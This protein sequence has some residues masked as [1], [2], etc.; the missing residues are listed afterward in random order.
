MDWFEIKNWLELSTG[1]DRDSLHIYAGVGVQLIVALILRRS[2]ASPVPW[3]LVAV[4]ALTN[5]YYDYSFVPDPLNA[6]QEYFDGAIRDVWNTLLLPS[7][8]LVI[9]RY[10]PTWLTGRAKT[11]GEP[12]KLD[13]ANPPI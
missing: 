13:R 2:L 12:E 1:L 11:V 6:T 4:A 8:L 3:L 7:L 9:A 5:E 10:W